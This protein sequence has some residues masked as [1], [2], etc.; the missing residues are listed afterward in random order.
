MEC[1]HDDCSTSLQMGFWDAKVM[2]GGRRV[3]IVK[4]D[5]GMPADYVSVCRWYSTN[6]W[7]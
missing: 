2:I 3:Q 6:G 7:E 5:V 1:C 4:N